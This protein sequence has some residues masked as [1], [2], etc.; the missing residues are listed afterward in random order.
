[1]SFEPVELVDAAVD[2]EVD[3]DA[4]ML[5][6]VGEVEDVSMLIEP[7]GELKAEFVGT[8]DELYSGEET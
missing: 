3:A 4:E 6:G 8:V 7:L 1:L 5:L 2:V